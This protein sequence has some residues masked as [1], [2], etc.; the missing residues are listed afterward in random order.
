MQSRD[1]SARA[2]RLQTHSAPAQPANSH[3]LLSRS[4]N[5]KWRSGI[6]RAFSFALAVTLVGCAVGPNYKR[7]EVN[8]PTGFRAA[9]NSFST[10]SFADLPWWGVFKDPVL[11]DLVRVALTNNYDLR[12]IL[13]R[14]D[15]ARALQMQAR[16]QFMP[17]VDYQAEA[18]RGRNSFLTVPTPNGGHTINGFLGGFEA[19]WEIDLWGRVRRMNEAARANFMATQEG[20]RT[21]MISVVSGVARAYFELLELD[22]QLTISRRTRNSY[23][24]TFRLFDDQHAAGLASNLEL[25][26]AK[27][28]LHTVSANIPELERQIG[29]KENEINT[30]LG[31]N[32]GPIPRTSTLLAQELPVEIPVGL[33]S[34]LLERRPDVRM[35]EQKVRAANAEIGVAVGDFFPRIGLT[36]FYGGTSTELHNLVSSGANVWSAAATAAGPMFTG[37]RLTGRY[38]QNKAAWEEAKLQYQDTA[39]GAFR[40]VSDALI[41]H[42]R[43][44]EERVEQAEAVN[45]GRDAVAVATDRYK[46][47]KASYY[48]VLEAQQQL[49]PAENTL[50]QI[51]AGRRLAVVQLYKALGGGWSLKDSEWSGLS[52]QVP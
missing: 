19:V 22:D 1:S 37:G 30:L 43:F 40:E 28:A 14:M 12:I 15:Q 4:I 41:S 44:D 9:N 35:A 11:Q 24:R 32:P 50:S 27:L 45:A 21:V 7:P 23:E 10:N 29:L 31:R 34:A 48:E 36:A 3:S 8:A 2:R 33:P 13:T 5:E 18:S 49:F 38:R 6:S 39:L 17:Q 46:E 20:R 52:A 25:S 42:R 26:R 47:G 16:S 51:E